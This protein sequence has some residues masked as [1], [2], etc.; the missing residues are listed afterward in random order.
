MATAVSGLAVTK[1]NA[2]SRSDNLSLVAAKHADFRRDESGIYLQMPR[3]DY[4][5]NT[6][7]ALAHAVFCRKKVF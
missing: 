6:N 3:E 4:G 1:P 7:H 5:P 2:I